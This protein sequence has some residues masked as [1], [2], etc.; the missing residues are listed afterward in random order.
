MSETSLVVMLGGMAGGRLERL[1]RAALEAS[2]L[3]VI[4]TALA[5]GRFD[6]AIL[7]VDVA[8]TLPV[9]AGVVVEVDDALTPFHYGR[10]LATAVAT[11]RIERLVYVGAGSGPLIAAEHLLALVDGLS[12]DGASCV[13]NNAYSADFFALRPAGLIA[14]LDPPPVA[15]NGVPRQLRE[16]HAVAVVE[17][18]RTTETQLNLDSPTDLAA[19]TLSGRGG[20]RLNA[21]LTRAALDTGRLARAARAFTDRDAEVFVA[22]RVGSLAWQYLER[23]TACRI[24]M[25]AEERGMTAAGR[26]VDG[27]ARSL[28]GQLIATAGPE[29]FFSEL[30][31]TLC[32]AALIDVRPALVQLGLHATAADRFAAD[33]GLPDEIAEPGLRTLVQAALAAPIPVVLGGHTL[34]AGALMLI[35]DW[36]WSEHDRL[37]GTG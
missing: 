32:D 27:G 20:P 21:L 6:R 5:T 37:V 1:M 35:N 24:R 29:R 26:D 17:L 36:A 34:V 18:P 9:P 11:H 7:L 2:A 19:L 33:A 13:T 10:R 28:L 31:P 3:D 22:G 25:L 23:E 16:Q 15:D 12:A 30:L 4:E 8:P 14:A